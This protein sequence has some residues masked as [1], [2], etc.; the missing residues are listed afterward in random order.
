[1]APRRV[2]KIFRTLADRY[3]HQVKR[4]MQFVHVAEQ[5]RQASNVFNIQIKDRSELLGFNC[6]RREES[7]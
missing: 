6:N 7:S 3:F 5:M 1:M 4:L 2:D